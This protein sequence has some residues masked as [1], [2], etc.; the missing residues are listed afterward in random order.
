MAEVQVEEEEMVLTRA[1]TRSQRKQLKVNQKDDGNFDLVE[2]VLDAEVVRKISYSEIENESIGDDNS[3]CIGDI[4]FESSTGGSSSTSYKIYRE[5]CSQ[6]LHGA[7]NF[8][9]SKPGLGVLAGSLFVLWMSHSITSPSFS[10]MRLGQSFLSILASQVLREVLPKIEEMVKA[11]VDTNIGVQTIQMTR[12]HEARTEALERFAQETFQ[13]ISLQA[14]SESESW[15]T[16]DQLKQAL[17]AFSRQGVHIVGEDKAV[18]VT[19]E[20]LHKVLETLTSD[21]TQ[22][23]REYVSQIQLSAAIESLTLKMTATKSE[24]VSR[25][26]LEAAMETLVSDRNDQVDYALEAFGGRIRSASPSFA[27]EKP[28]SPNLLSRLLSSPDHSPTG[29]QKGAAQIISPG[30]RPGRCWK[31]AGSTGYAV[32]SLSRTIIPSSVSL[33][34][35][36]WLVSPE[37]ATTPKDFRVWGVDIEDLRRRKQQN[38]NIGNISTGPLGVLLGQFTYTPS[39]PGR[40]MQN[41]KLLGDRPYGFIKLE[42]DSNY[43]STDLTCIYRFRVHG[44]VL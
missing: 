3:K 7:I 11:S 43:G 20:E 30:I 29:T 24:C 25:D 6:L 14:K 44:I 32:I 12:S 37:N 9:W 42:I 27:E 2:G 39:P 19:H 16:H 13:K 23:N 8:R 22:S 40:Q 36:S 26:Q 35:I 41:F 17:G 15:V 4:E 1:R 38:E 5:Q 34:H 31:M 21:T 28:N 18:W 33:E 10:G